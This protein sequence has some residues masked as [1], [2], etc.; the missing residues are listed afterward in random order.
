MLNIVI[1]IAISTIAIDWAVRTLYEYPTWILVLSGLFTGLLSTVA[2][3]AILF[4]LIF[5]FI[6]KLFKRWFQD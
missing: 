2:I 3:N 6:K 5:P 1:W 4:N